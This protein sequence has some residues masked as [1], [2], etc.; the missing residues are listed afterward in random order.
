MKSLEDMTVQ[1][2]HGYARAAGEKAT[3][4]DTLLANPET[5]KDALK[6]V[7]KSSPNMPIPELDAEAAADV[8]LAEER[9]ERLALEVRVRDGEIRERIANE[10]KR[11]MREHSLNDED[12]VEVEKLMVDEK[13]PIPH[14]DAAV[15]VFKASLVQATPTS[16]ALS[17][18]V[19][20]MPDD[21]WKKGIGNRVELDRIALDTA[22]TAFNQITGRPG[23]AAA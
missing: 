10:R 15:K 19:Y 8:K 18:P 16:A 11:V 3:L 7:K 17:A 12:M 20:T 23:K 22:Y 4:L 1:E 21:K 2:L 5:R 6:L 14:F 9:K 13:A